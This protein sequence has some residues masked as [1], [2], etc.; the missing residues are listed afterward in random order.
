MTNIPTASDAPLAGQRFVGRRVGA[1]LLLVALVAGVWLERAP[2]LRGM[3]DLWIVSDPSTPA[4][5]VAVLGGGLN[6]RPFAAAALYKAGLANKIIVSQAF[7]ER[8]TK[9]GLP[10]HTEL[11]YLVLLKLG[12]PEAAIGTFGQENASTDDEAIALRAWAAE[13]RVSRIIIP[14]EI[15]FSRRARWIFDREFVGS[16]VV[17]E[18]AAFEPSKYFRAEWWKSNGGIIDFQ[19]EFMKYLYYRIKY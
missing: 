19:N 5:V 6:E 4:D 17:L 10:G 3:A 14:T 2:L 13:H 16:A 11:N 1:I 12:V 9:L 18:I 7:Q 15:F 8:Y